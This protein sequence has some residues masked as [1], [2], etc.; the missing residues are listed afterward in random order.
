MFS[1]FLQRKLK[2]SS[3]FWLNAFVVVMAFTVYFCAYGFR[4]PFAAG[5]YELRLMLFGQELDYKI[6]MIITQVLGYAFAKFLGIKLISEVSKD[7]WILTRSIVLLLSAAGFSWAFVGLVPPPYNIVF[8]FINGFPLGLIWGLVFSFLEG[9]KHTEVLASGLSASFVFATA[10][11]QQIGQMILNWGISQYW[12]PFY[13]SMLYLGP[14]ILST[15]LLGHTPPPNAEDEALRTK[16]E[17]MNAQER[18]AFLREF[19]LGVFALTLV[20]M[21]FNAYREVR[22]NFAKE[23]WAGLGY[24]GDLSVFSQSELIISVIILVFLSLY[25]RIQN[26]AFAFRFTMYTILAGAMLVGLATVAFQWNWISG[27][28]WMFVIGLGAYM[29]YIPMSA[30]L[31]DRLLA[32]THW[33]GTVGFLIYL[34]DTFA[35]LASISILIIKNFF[36]IDFNWLTFLQ[37]L[38]Y[39]LALVNV[40]LILFAVFYFNAKIRKLVAFRE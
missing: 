36:F 19:G 18:S 37:S 25:Y 15:W 32:A 6:I 35:Y 3:P 17:P 28:T 2:T 38:G 23:I 5:T 34:M 7:A 24:V 31:F 20:Y 27:W 40:C 30:F 13:A 29:G 11:S 1:P 8:V 10:F 12:M 4:K 39:G 26:N 9:R 16:R 21:F 33:V 14:M 22:G